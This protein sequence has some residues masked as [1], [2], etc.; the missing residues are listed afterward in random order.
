MHTKWEANGADMDM[1]YEKWQ[2]ITEENKL[3]KVSGSQK[4]TTTETRGPVAS[5][6]EFMQESPVRK[7]WD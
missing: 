4:T 3:R 7:N 5:L 1:V 6:I 2:D